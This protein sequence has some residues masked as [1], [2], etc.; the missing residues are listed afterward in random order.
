MYVS[1]VGHP[2][3]VRCQDRRSQHPSWKKVN[4]A[5]VGS[6]TDDVLLLYFTGA[7]RT[8][9]STIPHGPIFANRLPSALTCR[10]KSTKHR[11]KWG[12]CMNEP[13]SHDSR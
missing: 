6:M 4:R 5:V 1:R 12:A 8:R 3:W 13:I 7:P 2:F 10:S 9:K 11:Q